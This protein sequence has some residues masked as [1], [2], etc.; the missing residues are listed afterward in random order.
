MSDAVERARQ[1]LDSLTGPSLHWGIS[2]A[3]RVKVALRDLLAEIDA[4]V[5]LDT[6]ELEAL[7]VAAVPRGSGT[8]D[9]ETA[10]DDEAGPYA[11]AADA[12]RAAR[13]AADA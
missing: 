12:V 3:E 10:H 5:W 6:R 1:A 7:M 8:W 4:G 9:W 11:T 13:E 2:D